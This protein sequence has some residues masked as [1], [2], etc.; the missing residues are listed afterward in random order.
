L[1]KLITDAAKC[2]GCGICEDVCSKTYFKA[3]DKSKSAIHI[4]KDGDNYRIEVCDQCGDCTKMCASM[5]VARVN[6]GVIR[7]TK[8][9]CVGCLICVAECLKGFMRYHDDEPVPFKCVAC[10]LCAKQCPSGALALSEE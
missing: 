5:A 7:I 1:K 10:G 8:D 4:V 6:N 3:V 9:K 2:T